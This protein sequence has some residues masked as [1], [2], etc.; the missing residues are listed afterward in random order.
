MRV[1]PTTSSTLWV[2][3][4]SLPEMRRENEDERTGELVERENAERGTRRQPSITTD[5]GREHRTTAHAIC[6]VC[7]IDGSWNSRAVRVYAWCSGSSRVACACAVPCSRRCVVQHC[8]FF[9]AFDS[10]TYRI[11]RV[12]KDLARTSLIV[13]VRLILLSEGEDDLRELQ[14]LGLPPVHDVRAVV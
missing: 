11:Y 9:L 12:S 7:A 2:D 13:A 6:N 10:T 5:A 4:R 8:C 14:V 3:A 1:G